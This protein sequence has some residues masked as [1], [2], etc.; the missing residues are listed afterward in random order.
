MATDC[1]VAT[2]SIICS[3]SS[4]TPTATETSTTRIT[5]PSAR[6]PASAGDAGFLWFLDADGDG[7]VDLATD[8]AAFTAQ[9]RK[10]L[11]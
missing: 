8:Y 1:R 3:V 10:T 5:S 9:N 6:P 4:A 7:I 2:T 11:A